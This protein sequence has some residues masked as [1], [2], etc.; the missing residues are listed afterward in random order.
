MQID[1][2]DEMVEVTARALAYLQALD[3]P[4][5]INA[6]DEEYEVDLDDATE[7]WACCLIEILEDEWR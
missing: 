6:G 7:F 5:G 3:M 4:L 1:I 2:S